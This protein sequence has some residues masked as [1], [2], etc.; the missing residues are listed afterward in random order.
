M[1]IKIF[2]YLSTYQHIRE[3]VLNA[4]D[5]VFNSGKL[6]LGPQ[7]SAFE[8]EFAQQVGAK[9]C[10]GV[11]SGT[12]ALHLA[13]WA[14]GV[15]AGDEVIT[16]ANTCPPT[17]SAIRLCGAKPVFVDISPDD[18]LIDPSKIKNAITSKTKAIISV[19]LWGHP[20][21]LSSLDKISQEH[22]LTLFEDCA[23]SQGAYYQGKH[24][25]T[26]GKAGC[27]SFYPTKNLGAY[28]DAGAI[29]T[30]DEKLATKISLMRMY[31]YDRP[32]YSIMEGMNARI[33][34]VQAAILRVKMGYLPK[35]LA[36]RKEIAAHYLKEI[37]NP[38]ITL[39]HIYSDREAAYHQFVIRIKNRAK[40]TALLGE[41]DIQYGIHY[42]VPIHLMPPYEKYASNLPV[43]ED[44]A[45]EILSIP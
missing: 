45:S 11:T 21:D 10:I 34:E 24:T 1:T 26:I 28:G 17:I 35:W 15:G 18:L 40:I 20:T 9:Y 2:D 19:H 7:T 38:A 31:G 42:P 43:C 30:D 39:P 27:F 37:D 32:N 14:D 13:M 25:G 29:V 4:V 44:V 36:R 16:V 3:E 5:D 12:T 33:S 23:Q 22:H 41:N 6:I 8:I